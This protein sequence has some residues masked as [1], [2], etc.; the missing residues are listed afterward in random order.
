MITLVSLE[1]DKKS[2]NKVRM[3]FSNDHHHPGEQPSEDAQKMFNGADPE[4][5]KSM[6]DIIVCTIGLYISPFFILCFDFSKLI[7]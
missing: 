2:S 3:N 6:N 7:F 4:F 1:S 5:E